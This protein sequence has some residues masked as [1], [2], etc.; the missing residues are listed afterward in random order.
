MSHLMNFETLTNTRDLG[1]MHTA[2][3]RTIKN[4]K[5]IRSGRL[6]D[7]SLHDEEVLSGLID[8]VVDFRDK[9]EKM[10][11][12]DVLLK[13]V[14]FVH[15][16]LLEAMAAGGVTRDALSEQ[17]I[18]KKVANDPE[19]AL[20][21]ISGIYLNLVMNDFILSQYR[22]FLLILLEHHDKAV[23]WHCSGG[24]DRAGI[25]A[26]LVEE[27]LGVPRE[28]V[29]ADYMQTNDYLAGT[30]EIILQQI[31]QRGPAGMKI[32]EEA[33]KCLYCAKEEYIREYYRAVEQRYGDFRTFLQEGLQMT[34]DDIARMRELYLE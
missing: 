28:D 30:I 17:E 18:L 5:L 6:S 10:E 27:I 20:K 24:K 9:A 12:P 7:L 4:R 25:G 15:L 8:T 14:T 19:K 21:M 2:D 34:E 11:H 31:Q 3:G 1:G 23:L 16:P 13:G 29:I 26:V 32:S 22:K 33:L